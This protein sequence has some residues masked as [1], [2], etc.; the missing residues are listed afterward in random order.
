MIMWMM[1]RLYNAQTDKNLKQNYREVFIDYDD[2][3]SPRVVIGIR[4]LRDQLKKPRQHKIRSTNQNNVTIQMSCN[5][6]DLSAGRSMQLDSLTNV[7]VLLPL[8]RYF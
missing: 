3:Q 5:L 7:S 8:T 1:G 2:V 4:S 6:A